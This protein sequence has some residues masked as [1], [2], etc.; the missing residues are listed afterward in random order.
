MTL[1]IAVVGGVA[2]GAS[3]AAKARR[4]DEFAEI[5]IFERGPYV[6]FANCGLPYYLGGAIKDRDE[7]FLVSPERFKSRFNIDVKVNHEVLSIERNERTIRVRDKRTGRESR[8]SYDRLIL[9]PGSVP[10][11]PGI[12]GVDG[13]RV[14][15]LWTVP[16]V[17]R[18]KGFIEE[19][20]PQK[21]VVVGGGFVGLE[22]TEALL[23]LGLHVHLVE[24]APQILTQMDPEMTAPALHHL[25]RFGVDISLGS[26]VRAFSEGD[27]GVN[28]ILAD[29]RTI[30]VDFV[31]LAV[32]SKPELDLPRGAGLAIGEAGGVVVDERMAT[33][34]PNIYAAGDIVESLHLITGRKVRIPLAGP[35][36]KQG[37]VAGANAA[38]GEMTFKGVLGTFIVKVC[39]LTL[40][41][42]GL[43]EREAREAGFRYRVSYTHSP[44]H[45]GYYPGAEM[46]VIKLLFEEGSGRLLGAQ[47]TGPEGVD[48]R[49][50]VLA[51][52][53]YGGMSVEDLEDLDLAY[54]PPY[55]SP[56]DPVIMA[57]FVGANIFRGEVNAITAAQLGRLLDAGEELQLVD[58]RT[59]GEFR[60]GRIPG[61]KLLPL[62]SLRDRINELD[63]AKPTV[64]YC[65]VAYR[66]YLAYKILKAYGFKDVRN[67]SGGYLSWTM[68]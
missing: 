42:T 26:G 7:L 2:A 10:L 40:A 62:D 31:I 3:A 54:A 63:P 59:E 61:A 11:R 38:G 44:H 8:V 57:G 66:S 48:K 23:D 55:S 65:G 16:D 45:A 36:N 12:E 21:A 14:F 34:D 20:K 50:D 33:N 30:K 46:M 53:L 1:K 39:D 4:T 35:A 25:R 22:A 51:T 41:R 47:V 32:G 5:T 37:R 9:A 43:N 13:E 27:G 19:V 17:D 49:I 68:R 18:L 6:S 52:A 24:A 67:L 56:K 15:T 60:K 29:G 28:V 58:V 64:V